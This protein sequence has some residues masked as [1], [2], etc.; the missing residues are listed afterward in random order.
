MACVALRAAIN[1][2]S[3]TGENGGAYPRSRAVISSTVIRFHNATASVSIFVLAQACAGDFEVHDFGHCGAYYSRECGVPATQ[4]G[5]DDAPLLVRVCAEWRV[6]PILAD[7]MPALHTISA[8]P[9][10][11][12]SFNTHPQV[13]AKASFAAERQ[14]RSLSKRSVWFDTKS[15]DDDVGR[16]LGAVD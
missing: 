14:A 12:H 16:Q 7:Q 11:L 5:T 15:A 8:G 9:D 4:V 3:Q 13:R 1:T 10:V 2:G 6:Y